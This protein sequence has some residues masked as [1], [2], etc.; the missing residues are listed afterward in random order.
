[1]PRSANLA[2]LS[3]TDLNRELKRRQKGGQSLLRK[4]AK[5]MEKIHAL[6]A[7]LRELGMAA[8]GGFSGGQRPR[9]ESYLVEALAAVLKG[10]TM[11]V[12]EVTEAVQTAGYKTTSPNFRTI[13]NQALIA[14]GKFKRVRRGQYT[15]K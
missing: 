11:S 9:N 14:S 3:V 4:R 15:A 12:T 1:V 5:L 7:R 13:V 6:D 8:G 2:K 10:K